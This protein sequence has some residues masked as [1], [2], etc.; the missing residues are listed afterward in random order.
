[1]IGTAADGAGEL[2]EPVGD[3]TTNGVPEVST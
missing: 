1:V 3:A 2:G